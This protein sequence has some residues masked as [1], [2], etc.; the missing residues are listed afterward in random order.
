MILD[1]DLQEMFVDLMTWMAGTTNLLIF[2]F[3]FNL[4]L[5]KWQTRKFL[6]NY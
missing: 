4:V 2:F 1:K 6:T 3:N 5:L